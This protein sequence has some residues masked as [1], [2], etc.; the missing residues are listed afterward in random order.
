MKNIR[1]FM[2]RTV[3]TA[4]PAL[5]A[6]LFLGMGCED[7]KRVDDM[8]QYMEDNPYASLERDAVRENALTV[9]PTLAEGNTIGQK[10][11]FRASGGSTPYQ[12]RVA[13]SGRGKLEVHKMNEAVY[14]VQR[15]GNNNVIVTD[16]LG[17][18]AIATI[19]G[20]IQELDSLT[21]NPATLDNDGDVSIL[22]VTGGVAP[23]SWSVEYPS[24]GNLLAT[25]GTSVSYVRNSAGDNVISVTDGTGVT[26]HLR[27]TQP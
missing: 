16:R 4:I 19:E 26:K 8:E 14:T 17:R 15:I 13:N 20:Q 23:Y 6:L 24:R 12:W 18:S 7:D 1:K 5:L 25:S 27:M 11:H 2:Q 10:L 21:A 9:N 3:V 22:T